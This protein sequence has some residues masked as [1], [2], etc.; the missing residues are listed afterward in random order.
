VLKAVIGELLPLALVVTISPLNIVPAILFL[1]TERPLPTALSFLLGFI[2]GVGLVLGLL[3]SL[4]G[5]IDLSTGS[6]HASWAGNLKI[7]LGA[8]LLVAAVRKFRGRF[9]FG[10]VLIGQGI[11]T[12]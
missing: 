3:I 12:A 1:S 2:V 5:A 6:G 11:S 10:V 9:V 7:I 4:G 8:Y